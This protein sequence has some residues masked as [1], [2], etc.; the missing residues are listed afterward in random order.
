MRHG[1]GSRGK[2]LL[3]WRLRCL[4]HGSR[5]LEGRLCSLDLE[6]YMRVG[7]SLRL[8]SNLRLSR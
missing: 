4:R 6:G 1:H 3:S 7:C 2:G 8:Q 5:G